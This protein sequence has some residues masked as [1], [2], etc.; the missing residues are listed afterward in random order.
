M[1]GTRNI[2]PMG[3]PFCGEI[4]FI[5]VSDPT[6]IHNECVIQCLAEQCLVKPRYVAA[7]A[8]KRVALAVWNTRAT[9]E[10]NTRHRFGNRESHNAEPKILALLRSVHEYHTSG[11]LLS[12][13]LGREIASYLGAN[14][15][16]PRKSRSPLKR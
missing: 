13:S 2:V 6:A 7:G 16:V 3:C 9:I 8:D 12:E 5:N 4:P 10:H 11:T 1:S 14:A 15:S